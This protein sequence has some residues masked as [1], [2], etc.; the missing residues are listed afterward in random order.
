MDKKGFEPLTILGI[1]LIIGIFFFF[2]FNKVP[3]AF[4]DFSSI[5]V[6]NE[7]ELEDFIEGDRAKIILTT[8]TICGHPQ[9]KS[10]Q[11]QELS[12]YAMWIDDNPYYCDNHD[13]QWIQNDRVGTFVCKDKSLVNQIALDGTKYYKTFSPAFIKEKGDFGYFDQRYDLTEGEHKIEVWAFLACPN[14]GKASSG[15]YPSTIVHKFTKTIL[16]EADKTPGYRLIDNVC[17]RVSDKSEFKTFEKCDQSKDTSGYIY[18]SNED[19]CVF[20]NVGGTYT[21]SEECET[22]HLKIEKKI[23]KE[24]PTLI[25]NILEWFK[26]LFSKFTWY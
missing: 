24:S 16:V 7:L 3:L 22:T 26:D 17:V 10:R 9:G 19:I 5:S 1:I 13:G 25:N 6:V 14:M 4:W 8:S 21:T 23:E 18:I 2:P 11:F 20:K 15:Y 12:G